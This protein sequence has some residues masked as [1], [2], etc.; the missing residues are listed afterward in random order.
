[1]GRRRMSG[2]RMGELSWRAPS[3]ERERSRQAAT[4]TTGGRI[5]AVLGR[6]VALGRPGRSPSRKSS[7]KAFVNGE[8]CAGCGACAGVCEP[9]AI[10]VNAVAAVDRKRCTGCGLC[11]EE[12]P[13]GAISLKG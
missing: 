7:A 4:G 2:A 12:C 8:M 5:G 6:I 10:T 1:M 11:V 13:N 3:G 9:R